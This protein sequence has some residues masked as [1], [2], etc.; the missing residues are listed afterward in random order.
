MPFIEDGDAVALNLLQQFQVAFSVKG[1][2]DA[3]TFATLLG[4]LADS[5]Q[6]LHYLTA[7]GLICRPVIS[8]ASQRKKGYLCTAHFVHRIETIFYECQV[9]LALRQVLGIETAHGDGTNLDT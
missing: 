3:H 8:A 5:V 2:V 9:I 4:S 1:R 6:A 7:L